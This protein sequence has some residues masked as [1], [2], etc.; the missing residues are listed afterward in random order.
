MEIAEL[1]LLLMLYDA[2]WSGDWSR[3]GA[4]TKDT[5][6]LLQKLSLVPLIGHVVTAVGAGVLASRKGKSP[7]V[8]AI[9]G[10]LFGALGLYEEQYSR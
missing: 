1:L 6:L 5:E 2:A 8:P 9:K 3:I 4:I 7:V 10:Y